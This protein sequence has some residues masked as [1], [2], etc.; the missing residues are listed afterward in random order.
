MTRVWWNVNDEMAGKWNFRGVKN[1]KNHFAFILTST[2]FSFF[3]SSIDI[4]VKSNSERDH[5][6]DKFETSTAFWLGWFLLGFTTRKYLN[7][8]LFFPRK[9][10][11][12]S[13]DERGAYLNVEVAVGVCPYVWFFVWEVEGV[14]LLLICLK[15]FFFGNLLLAE[16]D[17]V[18]LVL[19]LS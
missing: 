11:I 15:M 19:L 13:R 4:I 8:I 5:S 12:G 3:C 10:F 2:C 18:V 7:V 9:F 16:C 6:V 14:Y 1:T 17:Q